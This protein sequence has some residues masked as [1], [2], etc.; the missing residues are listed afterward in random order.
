MWKRGGGIIITYAETVTFLPL[1]LM[2]LI[3]QWGL[4]YNIILTSCPL[5]LVRVC[6]MLWYLHIFSTIDI[7]KE[8]FKGLGIVTLILSHYT[9]YSFNHVLSEL[10]TH[11][12]CC[13]S[14][15]QS[16]KLLR[17]AKTNRL[18]CGMRLKRLDVCNTILIISQ[19]WQIQNKYRSFL[20]NVH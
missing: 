6:K 8:L 2:T 4:I 19:C 5:G 14:G 9:S 10:K 13:L 1:K 17:S 20:F 18:N 7:L 12:S 15:W 11:T 16:A 3:T